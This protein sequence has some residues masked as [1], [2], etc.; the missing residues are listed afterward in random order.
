MVK[1]GRHVCFGLFPGWGRLSNRPGEA[2]SPKYCSRCSPCN[3]RVQSGARTVAV[4]GIG[5]GVCCL[6][7]LCLVPMGTPLASFSLAFGP[8]RSCQCW[9][10][11]LQDDCRVPP[12]IDTVLCLWAG[13]PCISQCE[14]AFWK[15]SFLSV[16]RREV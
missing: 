10:Q 2:V 5:I 14:T 16:G 8:V 4:A 7:S 12:F 11:A 6:L 1:E 13:T 15:W 3:V 9:Q